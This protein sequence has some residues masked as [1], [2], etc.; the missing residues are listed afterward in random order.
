MENQAPTVA[1]KHILVV[2][3]TPIVA[4]TINLLLS[5]LGHKVEI[6]SDGPGALIKF[7][8]GKYN[9]VITDYLM[10]KM[11]GIELAKAIKSQ[12]TGQLVLLISAFTASIF[13]VDGEPLP[14]DFVMQKPFSVQEFQRV[15]GVLFPAG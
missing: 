6:S 13:A 9:L 7:Q 5:H 12:A 3:D 15:L 10:P 1:K 11:N 4:E 2:D 14:V 8:S